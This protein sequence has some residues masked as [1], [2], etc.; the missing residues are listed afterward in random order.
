MKLLQN[1]IFALIVCLVAFAISGLIFADRVLGA[2]SNATVSVASIFNMGGKIITNVGTPLGPTDAV[3][4][5]WVDSRGIILEN[6]T[7]DPAGAVPG[8]M[9]IRTDQ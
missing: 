2:L 5:S 3:T 7:S 9:W 8:Q 1:K 4:K 6:R